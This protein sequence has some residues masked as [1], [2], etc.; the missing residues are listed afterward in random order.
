MIEIRNL[1]R[2]FYQRTTSRQFRFIK[3]LQGISLEIKRGGACVFTGSNGAGKTT[4]LRIIAGVL[5]P[6]SG[7]VRIQ[8]EVPE[9]AK[10]RIRISFLP[11]QRGGFYERLSGWDDLVFYGKVAGLRGEEIRKRAEQ[12]YGVLSCQGFI[13]SQV[14]TLSQGQKSRLALMRVLMPRPEIL[15]LDEPFQGIDEATVNALKLWLQDEF[16]ERQKGTLVLA[17][18]RA[19]EFS[20]LEGQQVLLHQGEVQSR[21]PLLSLPLCPLPLS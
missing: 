4:L 6:S 10:G 8:G 9:A 2:T 17:S 16:L 12:L 13:Y 18:Q 15:L 21:Q 14:Q 19:Q 5:L 11:S 7:E 1:S 3:A 20:G